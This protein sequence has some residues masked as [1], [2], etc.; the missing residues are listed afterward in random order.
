VFV[1]FEEKAEELT[2][3]VAS[4]GYDLMNLFDKKKYA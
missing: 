3:N 2:T 4:L 1:A